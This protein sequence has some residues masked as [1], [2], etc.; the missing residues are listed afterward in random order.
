MK[1]KYIHRKIILFSAKTV[2]EVLAALFVNLTSG[3]LG[4]ILIAPTIFHLPASEI[5]PTL[6]ANMTFGILGLLL[7]IFLTEKAKNL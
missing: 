5:I 3:W 4:V 1:R 2:L 7:S 6:T